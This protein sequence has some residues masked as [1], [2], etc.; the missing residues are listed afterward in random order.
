MDEFVY[1]LLEVDLG[2]GTTSIRTIDPGTIGRFI[3]GSGLAAWLLW[4]EGPID[5][6]PFSP[7]APLFFMTGPLTGTPVTSSGRHGVAGRSPLTGLWGEANV[8]GTWGTSLRKAGVDGVRVVGK[9]KKPVYLWITPGRAEIRDASHIWGADTFDTQA[10]I[11]RETHPKVV[12]SCIGPAGEKRVRIASVMTDGHH[13]R[14]AGRCGLGALMGS[15]NLKAIAVW[16]DVEIPVLM[17]KELLTDVREIIQ[18]FLERTAAL[19]M[20]GTSGLVL[21]QEE[22]GSF[23]IK[24]YAQDRWP[25]GARKISWPAM[26]ESIFIRNYRCAG[27][28]IACGRTVGIG[29]RKDPKAGLTAGP[30][31][32]TLALLGSNLLIGDIRAV[33]RMNELCNRLGIDTIEAG[34]LIGFAMEIFEKGLLPPG[35]TGGV[36]PRWGDTEAAFEII[37]Q[38][39]ESRGLGGFLAEGY[40]RALAALH[41]DAAEFAMQVK[42]LGLPA[43]DP[44]AYNS[45]AL[46]YATSNRGACHLQGFTHVFE[47]NVTEPA[48]GLH[49]IADRFGTDKGR[50]VADLQD[51]MAIYDS[52]TICKFNLFGG[53]K[54]PGLARWFEMVTGIAMGPSELKLA[55]ER[56]F[57]TKRLLSAHWGLTRSMDTLPTRMLTVAK[58]EGPSSGNL[59]PLETMLEQYYGARGWD[60]SG[61]PGDDTRR[62]LGIRWEGGP[63]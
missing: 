52:L 9:A 13:A 36:E 47:R 33:Q 11:Q 16:G 22:L 54:L 10:L 46:G 14:A 7:E 63:G 43:H 41:P 48:L 15:K 27:C 19:H 8:G 60:D 56:I 31:Y 35:L 17:R 50:M 4:K 18:S 21:P 40:P 57:N 20:A 3:G 6:E 25:E 55:G 29:A 5:P 37:R 34:S 2:A 23:P 53:V 1:R 45:V 38:M 30:E 44:R 28:V 49:E 62:R 26:E 32:E 58:K 39:G 59:P 61:K 12:V 42:G 24:N 51:L